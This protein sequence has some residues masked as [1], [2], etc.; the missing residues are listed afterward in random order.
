SASNQIGPHLSYRRYL[1]LFPDLGDARYVI[2][3]ET[4]P[5]YDTYINPVLN[6]QST[7]E[8]RENPA[9]RKIFDKNGVLVF[10]KRR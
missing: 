1:Y 8:L 6:L 5:G 7:R 4:E 2:L 9:Y 3:D 10:E